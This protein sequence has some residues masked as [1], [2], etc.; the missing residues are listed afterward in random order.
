MS[1]PLHDL[2]DETSSKAFGIIMLM[3]S[4]A[5]DRR[6]W[7]L[8]VDFAYFTVLYLVI[9]EYPSNP[10]VSDIKETLG[11]HKGA[12]RDALNYWKQRKVLDTYPCPLNRKF[13][14]VMLTEYGRKLVREINPHDLKS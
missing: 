3:W 8:R 6:G 10:T 2:L 12:I 13:H 9:C 14:R 7:S 5:A 1:D 11:K 4:K